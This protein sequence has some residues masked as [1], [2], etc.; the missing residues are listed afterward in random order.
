LAGDNPRFIRHLRAGRKS[1]FNELVLGFKD[2]VFNTAYR[3]LGDW[4]E[5]NDVA[6][7][8]FLSVNK[9]L[10]SFRAKSLL[11][12]WVYR[13]TVN[14]CKNRLKSRELL[15]KGAGAALADAQGAQ[16]LRFR[17]MPHRLFEKKELE[18]SVQA[19]IMALT[20]ECKEIVLLRDIEGLSYGQIGE[21]L[22][23]EESAVKS[24]LSRARFA[25][26]DSLSGVIDA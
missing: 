23:I 10:R 4:Q 16:N 20:E 1:A 24:R 6:R 5:A 18:L 25:L 12:A 13:N 9:N 26:K 2:R 7:E 19:A 17:D 8:V 22:G 21:I 14:I 11:S 15:K 3:F